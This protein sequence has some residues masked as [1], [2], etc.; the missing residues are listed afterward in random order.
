MLYHVF[1]NDCSYIKASLKDGMLLSDLYLDHGWEDMV[2]CDY[3]NPA[4]P[5]NC[6][7]HFWVNFRALKMVVLH[8]RYIP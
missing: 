6:A 7:V 3:V 4:L 2:D 8:L 1:S 5:F